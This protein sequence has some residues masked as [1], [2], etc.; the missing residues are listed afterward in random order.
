MKRLFDV[1]LSFISLI[2]LIPVFIIIGILILIDDFGNI[3]YIQNRVGKNNNDFKL[4]KFRTMYKYS[5]KKGLLTIGGKDNRITP[6]G[7]FVRKYKLDEL[8]QLINVLKGDMSFV[9]PRPEVRKYVDLYNNEQ[10]KVLN[11]RPGITDYASI[12]Y[13]NENDLLAKS[14]N[15]EK[16]YIEKIMPHKLSINLDYINDNSWFK[17]LKIIFN[18][19]FAV[20]VKK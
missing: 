4:L 5:D 3:F 16:L 17:D 13:K 15:P 7:R 12:L 19:L 8:P 2:V 6:I 11:V 9:G 20:F 18:T 1:V 14:E 10:L